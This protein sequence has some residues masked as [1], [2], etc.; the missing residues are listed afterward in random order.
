M[1]RKNEEPIRGEES[2][3]DPK[4]VSPPH[5]FSKFYFQG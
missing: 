5:F 1:S 2:T 3:Q 4:I